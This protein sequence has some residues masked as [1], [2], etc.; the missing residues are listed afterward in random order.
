MSD[1]LN[2]KTFQ[3]GL[4]LTLLLV[5]AGLGLYITGTIVGDDWV[6]P[7]YT[8]PTHIKTPLFL[9]Y[10]QA[11]GQSFG[12]NLD[13]VVTWQH[14]RTGNAYEQLPWLDSILFWALFLSLVTISVTLTYLSRFWYLICT[15]FMLFVLMQL[16]INE[17]GFYSEYISYALLLV[18]GGTTY[19]F[20]NIKPHQSLLTRSLSILLIYGAFTVVIGQFSQVVAPV[21]I[22]MS[23]GLYTPVLLIILFMLFIGADNVYSLFTIATRNAPTGKNGLIHFM[24]IGLIYIIVLLLLFLN[25]TGTIDLNLFLID[26]YLVFVFAIVSGYYCLNAKLEVVKEP[27]PLDLIKKWLYPALAGLSLILIGYAELS[28]NDSLSE[29]LQ[30]S[31]LL[32]Q[33]SGAAVFYVY[34]FINFAPSLLTNE[35]VAGRFFYGERAPLLTGRILHL[36]FIVA[37]FFYLDKQP[38]FQAKAARYNALAATSESLDNPV[39][40]GEYYKQSLFYDFYGLKANYVLA[41]TNMAADDRVE[42]VKKLSNA[43]NRDKQGKMRLALANFYT[44]QNQLFSKLLALKE[45]DSANP[46]VH[47]NLGLAY[48]EFQQ[49]DSAWM[50]FNRADQNSPVVE[51][52]LRALDYFAINNPE[53]ALPEINQKDNLRILANV[54]AI[55]NKRDQAFEADLPLA[56]DTVLVQEALFLLYNQSLRPSNENYEELISTIDYY[57]S[58]PRNN[59]IR[60]FILLGRAIQHYHHGAVNQAFID[61]NQLTALYNNNRGQYTYMMGLWAAQQG[62]FTDALQYLE[63]ATSAGFAPESVLSLKNLINSNAVPTVPQITDWNESDLPPKGEKERTDILKELASSNSFDVLLT[64]NA[65]NTLKDDGMSAQEL[66]ELLRQAISINRYSLELTQAYAFQSIESGL[67]VF[68]KSALTALTGMVDENELKAALAEFDTRAEA[69]RNRP[70]E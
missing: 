59:D 44:E 61:L 7:W 48:Y 69:W 46:K 38:F 50:A 5:V 57:L 65:I 27:L 63:S 34:V 56:S 14:Y 22:S 6:L 70:P 12:I 42:V 31:I 51:S 20:Q 8:T 68:G 2:H 18:F 9:E 39:L 13:Q 64:L 10:F 55:A 32:T 60:D 58:S 11:N 52:N 62:G 54:Q 28:G 19:F 24:S 43:L 45:D 33:L 40:A 4:T 25:K 17:L 30:M 35:S 37:I 47:N 36:V 3:T 1:T 67:T 66:Y 41:M 15:G 16:N 29:V 53:L 21:S 23:F 49:Y 26:S